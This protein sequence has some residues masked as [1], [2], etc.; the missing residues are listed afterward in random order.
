VG[1]FTADGSEDMKAKI[2]SKKQARFAKK[3]LPDVAQQCVLSTPLQ[4]LGNRP[5]WAHGY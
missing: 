5:V 2:S 4:T 3:A 1:D